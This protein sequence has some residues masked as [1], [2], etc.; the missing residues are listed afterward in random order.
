MPTYSVTHSH[1]LQ[2]S[3]Y[4]GV[5]GI[6]FQGVSSKHPVTSAHPEAISVHNLGNLPSMAIHPVSVEPRVLRCPPRCQPQR[7]KSIW[8]VFFSSSATSTSTSQS[9]ISI[10]YI[11]I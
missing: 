2:A 6:I 11:H 7:Y 8:F 4:T 3:M 1:Y 5:H 9:T 10:H